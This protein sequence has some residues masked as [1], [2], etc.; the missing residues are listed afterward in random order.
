[1]VTFIWSMIF[2]Y[3]AVVIMWCFDRVMSIWCRLFIGMHLL[4]VALF[5]F[6][7]ICNL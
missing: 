2:L 6:L 1:M 5:A 4:V 7:M 3:A